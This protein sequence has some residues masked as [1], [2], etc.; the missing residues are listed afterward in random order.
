MTPK[1]IERIQ[2]QIVQIKRSLA[3]DKK[4]HGGFYDDSRGLRY[5]SPGLYIKLK[6]YRGALRYFQWFDKNFD[7]DVGHPIFLFEWAIVLFKNDKIKEAEKMVLRTFFSNTFLMDAFLG[8]ESLHLN[9]AEDSNWENH[10]WEENLN[11]QKTSPELTDFAQWLAEFT[12]S[13]KFYQYA[14]VFMDIQRKL[15]T[16]PSG[17]TRSQLVSMRYTLLDNYQ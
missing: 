11:Y 10:S 15:T 7:D 4:L 16:E 17:V 8:K 6:D 14:N 3:L 13:Q 1:Q 2:K 12:D 9:I 5:A